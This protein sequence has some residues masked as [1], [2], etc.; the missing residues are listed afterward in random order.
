VRAS[1]ALERQGSQQELAELIGVSEAR[2]SQIVGEGIVERGATLR[3][4]LLAYC[5]WVREVAAGRG[6]AEIG[7]LDLVQERAALA[8]EQRMGIEIKNAVLRGEFA[9]ISVLAEVLA[10]ASQSIVE[11]FDQLPGLLKKSC[12]DLPDAAREQVMT[13]L[14]AARNE[15]VRA[16]EALVSTKAQAEQHDDADE[17]VEV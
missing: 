13:A 14:A 1:E 15:W 2:V 3:A 12:P 7:G 4:Q 9:P 5:A 17:V 16:T 11:R 6:S 8:R 10:T